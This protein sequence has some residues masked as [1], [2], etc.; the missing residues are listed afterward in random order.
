MVSSSK[1]FQRLVVSGIFL[2]AV[3]KTVVAQEIPEQKWS[4]ADAEIMRLCQQAVQQDRRFI[5]NDSDENYVIRFHQ[6]C[7]PDGTLSGQFI[8][9]NSKDGEGSY[10]TSNIFG[11]FEKSLKFY[12]L[13]MPYARELLKRPDRNTLAFKEHYPNLEERL[14]TLQGQIDAAKRFSI[15]SNK[16]CPPIS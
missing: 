14:E 6:R 7:E 8:I 10:D 9:C 3:A 12:E 11:S 5:G 2:T 16:R 4:K 13:I 1:A 15:N